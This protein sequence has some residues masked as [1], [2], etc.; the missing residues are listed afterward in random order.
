M[1]VL[2][3]GYNHSILVDHCDVDLENFFLDKINFGELKHFWWETYFSDPLRFNEWEF[4]FKDALLELE[5]PPSTG[6]NISECSDEF[7]AYSITLFSFALTYW[8][9]D[10][11]LIDFWLKKNKN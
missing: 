10:W 5:L 7:G 1:D 8:N 4:P 2:M 9:V 11:K 3:V 6:R